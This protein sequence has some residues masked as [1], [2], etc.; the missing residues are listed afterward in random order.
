MKICPRC[1]KTYADDNLNFCL[2]D[3]SVLTQ[4][5][6][7]ALPQTVMMSEPRM[8]QPQQSMPS[9]PGSQPA[10]SVPPQQYSMQPPAKSSKT[11]I[12][13]VGIFGIMVLVCGGGLIAFFAWAASQVNSGTPNTMPN[14]NKI[15]LPTPIGN[16]PSNSSSNSS[17]TSLTTVDLA[18]MVHGSSDYGNTEYTGGEY[19]MS[20]KK[21]GYYYVVATPAEH[22]TEMADTRVTVRNV[23]NENS[24][25]GY[26]LVFHSNPTPLQQDYAF[27]IDTQKKKY[28]VVHHEPQK[29]TP[30]VNWTSSDS[31]K[32]GSAENTLEVRDGPDKFELYI[33]G[34]MVTSVKNIYGYKGGVAGL[35][36]GDGVKIGF[37]NFEIRK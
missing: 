17:R 4:A 9:Q 31:I 32:G 12:W 22:K 29:E 6:P 14:G 5:P 8:T 26:G 28:S 21:K 36:S 7:E 3:G 37:K 18:S 20:S 11:W 24:R 27:L 19:L 2:E 15:T 30:V 34:T 25:L 10:W 16:R 35:Y 33:N 23:N 13:V 1:Q